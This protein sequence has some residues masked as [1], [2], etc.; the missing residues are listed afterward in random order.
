MLRGSRRCRTSPTAPPITECCRGPRASISG[1]GPRAQITEACSPR[2]GRR[3]TWSP[4]SGG[5]R[6]SAGS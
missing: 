5:S 6:R 4:W 1:R 3:W 2:V